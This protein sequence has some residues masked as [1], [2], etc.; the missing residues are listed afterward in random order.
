MTQ[1]DFKRLASKPSIFR[2]LAM[3]IW[4]FRVGC[5]M[6]IAGK[7]LKLGEPYYC[8]IPGKGLYVGTLDWFIGPKS[9][10]VRARERA[11]LAAMRGALT[12][13]IDA[14]EADCGVPDEG[15]GDDEP[16]GWSG[17]RPMALQFGMMR[18][19]RAALVNGRG[20]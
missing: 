13:L 4:S 1:V 10:E 17:E 7:E 20:A 8:F 16:V 2:R 11:E 15:D 9:E 18:R 5:R 19:A 6:E 12:E 14:C 3:A